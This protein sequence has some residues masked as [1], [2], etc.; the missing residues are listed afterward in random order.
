MPK[1]RK[2]PVVI[3]AIQW[4]KSGDNEHVFPMG[5]GLSARPHTDLTRECEE[6]KTRLETHGW[7]QTLEGIHVVCPGD[8]I[9]TGVKGERYPCKPDIFEMTYE[10]PVEEE[11]EDVIEALSR[12]YTARKS[13]RSAVDWIAKV[14]EL[15]GTAVGPLTI[16]IPFDTPDEEAFKI[17][18]SQI[19]EAQSRKFGS[20][21]GHRGT[22][23]GRTSSAA[24][25]L[26]NLPR[27]PGAEK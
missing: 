27:E 5:T 15:T 6:C 11:D 26:T 17:I 14:P 20:L 18:Q 24:P 10:G 22:T 4:L 7:V 1:F 3:E 16:R 8:W 9:I 25:N 13:A 21:Y 2:K 12:D 23:T 19:T